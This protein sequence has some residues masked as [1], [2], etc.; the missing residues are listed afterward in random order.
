MFL[1]A[2]LQ[3]CLTHSQLLEAERH[4]EK[5]SQER[6]VYNNECIKAKEKLLESP[7]NPSYV[8]VGFDYA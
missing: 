6:Q 2:D 7:I 4:L 3:T 8:H 1:S 5:A